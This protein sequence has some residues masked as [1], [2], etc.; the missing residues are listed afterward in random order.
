MENKYTEEDLRKAYTKGFLDRQD[1]QFHDMDEL[2]DEYIESLNPKPVEEKTIPIT[3]GMIRGTVGW[4]KFCDV[5]GDNHY[6]VKEWGHPS[7]N[8][9][10]EITQEQYDELF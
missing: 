10:Y 4:L 9:I 6:A 5:T 1:N 2:L 3:Y 7:D 8:E